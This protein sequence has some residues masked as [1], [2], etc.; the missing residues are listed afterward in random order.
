MPAPLVAALIP[1]MYGVFGYGAMAAVVAANIIVYGGLLA[2]SMGASMLLARSLKP[3]TPSGASLISNGHLITST[4]VNDC[5]RVVYGKTRVAGNRVMINAGGTDNKKLTV[6]LVWSEGPCSGLVSDGSGYL[7]Y[8]DH[9]R[10]QYYETFNGYDLVSLRFHNGDGTQT[11]DALAK[12][13]NGLAAWD[14]S[15]RWSCYSVFRLSYH[16]DAWNSLP[17]ITATIQGRTLYDPRDGTTQWGTGAYPQSRNPALVW[18]DFMTNKRYG[19]GIPMSLINEQSVIDAANALDTLTIQFDGV[20]I[21]RRPFIENLNSI[22][23]SSRCFMYWS[24]GQYYIKVSQYDTPVMRLK[25]E[26]FKTLPD[27]FS[28]NIPGIPETPNQVNIVFQDPDDNYVAKTI[29]VQDSSYLST[30][31]GDRTSQMALVGI[32]HYQR[33]VE[34][35]A[36]YLKR[37]RYNKTF[38]VV[39]SPRTIALDPGDLVYATHSFTGW[40]STTLRVQS[41]TLAPD[42]NVSLTLMEESS[43]IYDMSGVQVSTHSSYE[44]TLPDHKATLTS[45]TNCD[46]STGPDEQT[47]DNIHD[48]YITFKCDNMGSYSYTFRWRKS[49]DPNWTYHTVEI[50]YGEI[51]EP[52][53]VGGLYSLSTLRLFSGGDYYG[54]DD[55]IYRIQIDGVGVPNTFKWSQDNGATWSASGVSCATTWTSLS[56]GLEIKWSSTTGG[57]LEE[58][59]TIETKGLGSLVSHRVGKL[60]CGSKIYWAVRTTNTKGKRSRW[61]TSTTIPV[62]WAPEIPSMTDYY[63]TI[64]IH[65]QGRQIKVDWSTWDGYGGRVKSAQ[66]YSGSAYTDQTTNANNDVRNDLTLMGSS[67]AVNDAYYIGALYRFGKVSINVSRVGKGIYTLTWEY[68]NG[69]AWTALSKVNDGTNNFKNA[70]INFV[71]FK[72]PLDWAITTV[73]SI[74]A[75]YVRARIS[76]FTSMSIQPKGNKVS[77]QNITVKHYNIH[78]STTI[79]CPINSDTR[80]AEEIK[81]SPYQIVGLSKKLTYDVRV[82]PIGWA[83][84]G[85]ASD[86]ACIW[87]DDCHN[88]TNAGGVKFQQII[89]EE[90]EP[91]LRFPQNKSYI[92]QN[93]SSPTLEEHA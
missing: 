17:Q 61:G 39:T 64:T 90:V 51:E 25:E 91:G 9:R 58:E 93:V 66:L 32:A 65:K 26:D 3:S 88:T 30:D 60:E 16:E 92:Y 56:N 73:N 12:D 71:T 79:P 53:E 48:A 31:E 47:E 4:G 50:P 45:P 46:W 40:S 85:I 70:G 49:N 89:F 37:Q 22:L 77:V 86:E 6:V 15:M 83:G 2:I 34:L 23:E 63:P 35:G 1:V 44:S 43:A 33:A 68:W 41:T 76:L 36:Y 27:Q 7:I 74:S 62:T 54:Q 20:I 10:M 52:E 59:W 28:I 42:G 67:P 55:L 69:S 81:L 29:S 84:P 14:E 82:R 78:A 80:I 11:V 21:D 38:S 5:V 19:G 72:Y 75:Y 57:V 87:P 24:Q 13:S 18:Y 8:F